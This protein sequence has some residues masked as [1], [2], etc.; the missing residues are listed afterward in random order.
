MAGGKLDKV[1]VRVLIAD[2]VAREKATYLEQYEKIFKDNGIYYDLFLWDRDAD[3]STE[4]IGNCFWF[5]KKCTAGGGNKFKKIIPMFKYQK[6][7]REIIKEGNYSH[8]VLINSL[9]PVMI[10][11]L[12]LNKYKSRYILDVR[13][14]TYE[15]YSWYLK[16]MRQLIE[17]SFFTSI[18]SRGFIK[19]LGESD[20]FIVTHNISNINKA[21]KTTNTTNNLKNKDVISIGFVGNVR[22]FEENKKLIKVLDNQKFKLLYIGSIDEGCDIGEYC[23]KGKI[24]NVEVHG[25]FNNGDKP[26]I[27][28]NID[29]IN[30]IYG[31]FSLEVT[32]ALPNRLYD[33]LLFKKTIL[34]SKGTYLGEIVEKYSV[35]L[36]VDLGKDD[37]NEML[38]EYINKIDINKLY[39]N[40]DILLEKV[41]AEQN[42]YKE[43]V[44]KFVVK[45]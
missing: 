4:K 13:D 35:G 6:K 38:L 22:Y 15:K 12:V 45:Q 9:A 43:A 24:N 41:M 19:F 20:K 34:A 3:A 42:I 29:I 44:E 30:S 26:T 37:I 8:L 18:S 40:I 2:T 33:A 32:T 16:I 39:I 11:D 7:L 5:H 28:E 25:K 21:V 36:A 23:A 1:M 14:Y 10:A 27:Y 31:D 17:S